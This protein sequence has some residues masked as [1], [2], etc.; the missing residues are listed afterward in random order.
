MIN[1]IWTVVC[2]KSVIDSDTNNISLIDTIERLRINLPIGQSSN[3]API[4]ISINFEIVSLWERYPY[5]EPTS[6]IARIRI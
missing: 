2:T 5:E 4:N 6:K 3:T 1:H